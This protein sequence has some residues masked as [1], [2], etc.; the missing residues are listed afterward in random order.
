MYMASSK[1][2]KNVYI[3]SIT[4]DGNKKIK[5]NAYFVVLRGGGG[6]RDIKGV[7]TKFKI[8]EWK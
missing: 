4:I 2:Y 7:K 1:K 3:L 8:N 5:T 6:L